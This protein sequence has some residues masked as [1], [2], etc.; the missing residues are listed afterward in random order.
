MVPAFFHNHRDVIVAFDVFTVPTPT[1]RLLCC[2]FV[3]QQARA[4]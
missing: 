4:E 1:F 2:S 3:I